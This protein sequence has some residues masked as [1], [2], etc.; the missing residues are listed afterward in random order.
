MTE[1][2]PPEGELPAPTGVGIRKAAFAFILITVLLDVMSLGIVIPVWPKLITGFTGSFANAGWWVGISGTTW[3]VMQFFCQP[4]IGALSDKIGRRPVILASNLGTGVD[5][6]FMAFSPTLPLLLVGRMIS[7]ATSAT[8]GT[9]FAYI[10]DVTAPEKR[11]QRFG[12]IGAIFGLGFFF[13]PFLGGF[14]G[15]ARHSLTIPGT[16]WVFQGGPRVPFMIA[17]AFSLIN[18]VYGYF[19]LPESLSKD[20]RDRFRWS[21]ANPVGALALLRSHADLLPLAF[22]NFLAQLAHMGLQTVFTL[23]AAAKFRWEPE[24]IGYAMMTMGV[25]AMIVQGALV[26][27]VVK[28][29]GERRAIF[30]GLTFGA[31]GFSIYALAPT[32]QIFMA[33]VPLM[34]MWGFAGPP[35]QS[36]MTRRVGVNEQGKLQGANQGVTS[37]AAIFGPGLYGTLY[38]L[39]NGKLA[40][41]GLPGFPF[42][43]SSGFLLLAFIMAFVAAKDAR[44]REAVAA[45]E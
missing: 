21:R 4:I 14:F 30:L 6:F 17:G 29:L 23:H 34:S 13:G 3:A 28:L 9:A 41:L 5:W 42:L 33:G 39:F 32:W 25:C 26:G 31:I 19:V 7:G 27:P 22:V 44:A 24:Q 37:I 45:A 15:D 2:L 20:R 10:A 16:D 11:A 40:Y 36:I 18:F 35:V 38:A 43:V 1:H 8:I 12:L